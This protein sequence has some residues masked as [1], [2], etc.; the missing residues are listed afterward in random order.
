MPNTNNAL[1]EDAIESLT[2]G[3][4]LFDVQERLVLCN[5]QLRE[6][7]PLLSD[8]LNPGVTME[9]LVRA[10]A[11]ATHV[12][13]VDI[14]GSDDPET[15]VARRMALHRDAPSQHQQ[16]TRSGL[17]IQISTQP[18]RDGGR[19]VTYTDIT[20]LKQNEQALRT[21]E[22][23]LHSIA[24]NLPGAIFRRVVHAD[25]RIE[26]TYYGGRP[27][28]TF[29][30]DAKTMM[31]DTDAL[32]AMHHPDDLPD[33]HELVREE[34]RR[35]LPIDREHR[36]RLPNGEI[37]WI[38]VIARPRPG[39]DGDVI[40]DGL[41]VDVT[42]RK[43]AEQEAAGAH[44][45][46]VDVLESMSEGLSWFDR[47]ERFVMCNQRMLEIHD[48]IRDVFVPGRKL[49]D[50][51]RELVPREH[52]LSLEGKREID[53]EI[54]VARRMELH[55]NAPSQH[56]QL[57]SSGWLDVHTRPTSDGGRV[58]T[59]H[60]IGEQKLREQAL[61]DKAR[62]EAEL[63]EAQRL[64]A[65][66]EAADRAKSEFLAHMSHELR[67]P[68]NGILG[69]AQLLQHDPSLTDRQRQGIDVIRECGD[70]L[71]SLINDILDLSRIEAGKL[72]LQ[73]RDFS[74]ERLLESLMA[75]FRP[76]AEGKGLAFRYSAAAEL[77]DTVHGDD[78]KLRQVL[79]NLLGNA[80]KFTDAGQVILRVTHGA[81]RIGFQVEDTGVGIPSERLVDL[82][83]PFARLHELDAPREGTG[84]GL[85]ISHRL[86]ALMG[87][88]LKVDSTP[89]RGSW[90]R[91]ELILPPADSE[92]LA[93]DVD[94]PV[95]G[96]AGPRRRLLIADDKP[97][98]RSLLA[99]LL[100]PLGFAC[101][102]AVDGEDCVVRAQQRPPDLILM[103]LV[104]PRL[105]GLAATRRL[106]RLPGLGRVPIIALSASA[107]EIN[108]QQCRAAGCDDFLAKPVQIPQ[109]LK[110]LETLLNLSWVHESATAALPAS[111]ALPDPEPLPEQLPA[112]LARTLCEAANA[113]RA[114][115][116][117]E[118]A[119]TLTAM[120]GP[121][122]ALGQRVSTLARE[123]RF[124]Q[125]STLI[126]PFVAE[127]ETSDA[128]PTR[129][130][131]GSPSRSGHRP[132]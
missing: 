102:Q 26:F 3:F 106:R 59:W 113:G 99:G 110:K 43:H 34:S 100:Q 107:F 66:K 131:P 121:Y 85:A 19:V 20:D 9:T 120:G 76:R 47:E 130:A 93:M 124:E 25:G 69:Y 104:M 7:L 73:A 81:D 1:L 82:F 77:P 21:S 33:W 64:A 97:V 103:D 17:W 8:L 105:D 74:L 118:Q 24:D 90:F 6:I 91:F 112:E 42:D 127:A 39:E 46:L 18:T 4:A 96:Y 36:V 15:F 5:R 22:Q 95:V 70:H 44:A 40:W 61:R 84:L 79:I 111:V 14:C 49:E 12:Q 29:G 53:V 51:V 23:R 78:R 101:E 62:M 48:D 11:R 122:R 16:H 10:A 56:E 58:V 87:G 75:M 98:N 54:L 108:R 13:L 119:E 132:A 37:K 125:I 115:R 126:E 129:P 31:R 38:R 55:R 83:Q 27:Q 68:L 72:T 88:E 50:I 30:L 45:Q 2:E 116:V 28:E 92:D 89:G 32:I 63:R 109:L 41:D 80:V 86:V 67:T 114:K 71:L 94:T 65:T 57:V 117:L 60:D 123:F 52:Y 35:M 128:G